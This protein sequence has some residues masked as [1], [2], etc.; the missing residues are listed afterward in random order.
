MVVK[1]LTLLGFLYGLP[2]CFMYW[3]N[4]VA[5]SVKDEVSNDHYAM[6]LS[7]QRTA[8][9]HHALLK[10]FEALI[11]PDDATAALLV[12]SARHE[13]SL[14]IEKEQLL[15]LAPK[16][17]VTFKSSLQN[18]PEQVC[19]CESSVESVHHGA[20]LTRSLMYVP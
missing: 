5:I 1:D 4:G 16:A 17:S 6:F 11:E 3:M 10:T 12:N 13:L 9:S 15:Y 20:G 2:Q 7:E 8:H 18:S 14:L 19:L